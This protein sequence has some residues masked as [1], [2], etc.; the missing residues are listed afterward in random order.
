[1]EFDCLN[2]YR[3]ISFD[4]RLKCAYLLP[5]YLLKQLTNFVKISILHVRYYVPDRVEIHFVINFNL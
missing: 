4:D 3:Y 5:E 1:M 2:L